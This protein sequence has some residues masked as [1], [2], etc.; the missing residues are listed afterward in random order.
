MN[1]RNTM[2]MRYDEYFLNNR[3]SFPNYPVIKFTDIPEHIEYI[4]F[5][6][7]EYKITKKQLLDNVPLTIK[8]IYILA[9]YEDIDDVFFRFIK[10]PFGCDVEVIKDFQKL[11]ISPFGIYYNYHLIY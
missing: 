5:S 1:C 10:V 2:Y 7:T 6:K 3:S 8:K 11:N 9:E 4:I